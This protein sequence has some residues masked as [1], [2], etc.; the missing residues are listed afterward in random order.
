MSASSAHV[1]CQKECFHCSLDAL[2][3]N[4]VES[5]GASRANFDRLLLASRFQAIYT[6]DK[7]AIHGYEGLLKASLSGSKC[8][9]QD[10][11]SEYEKPLDIVR[12][13]RTCR[14]LH[15]RNSVSRQLSGKLFLNLDPRLS[16]YRGMCSPFFEQLLNRY[17]VDASRIVIEIIESHIEDISPLVDIV[18]FYRGLGCKVAVDDFGAGN[19]NFDRLCQIEPDYIK[20]DK[21]F[22]SKISQRKNA[23]SF[24]HRL[25]EL[26]HEMGASVVMEG[27]ENAREH[28]LAQASGVDFV[29]GYYYARPA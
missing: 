15:I 26:F 4:I 7:K 18:E 16:Q 6:P 21:V 27:V 12:L 22:I 9:I 28:A 19:S 1:I 14:G 24:I 2:E 20:L 3:G 13:D 29:Q 11:F 5:N 8:R 25:V 17:K 10:V 23:Q